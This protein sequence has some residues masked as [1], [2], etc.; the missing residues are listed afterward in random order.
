[1]Q[2]SSILDKF[3]RVRLMASPTPI[4]RLERLEQALG[5][6]RREVAIWV[7]RDDLMGLGG[8]GNKLRKLEFLLAQARSEGCD[9]VIAIGGVQSNFARLTAAA[10]ARSGLACELVLAQMVPR[11]DDL[12]HKNG[13]VLLDN[14][15][16]AR[17]HVLSTGDDPKQ[18]AESR[19]DEIAASG[20]RAFIATLG[21]ST[22]VGCLGYVDCAFEIAAQSAEMDIAFDRI[23]I[24]NGSGGT[25]AGLAAGMI[26]TGSSAS[27][28]RAHSVV[29]SREST[30]SAT[31][32]KVNAVLEL[33]SVEKRVEP[34]ELNVSGGQLG[35]GYGIPT[36]AMVDAVRT[37]ARSEGLLLDPVY[38]GKA[39]AGLLSDIEDGAIPPRS[40]VLFVMTGGTPA[41][42][43]Y[44]DVFAH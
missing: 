29:S 18:F 25:H 4:Q 32:D 33:L 31:A 15:F 23:V 36:A 41:L 28:V 37:V 44:A 19:A 8:G 35:D 42:Y 26:V 2:I 38:S 24:P 43:A 9:T 13:N 22:P 5:D 14:L 21:G 7:K 39:F 12:Y 27:R 10:C 34:D 17:L 3:P 20:G 30:M 40:N 6:R 16:G 1:M 11:I